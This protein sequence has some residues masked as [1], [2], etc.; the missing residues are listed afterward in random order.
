MVGHARTL[1]FQSRKSCYFKFIKCLIIYYFSVRMRVGCGC[2]LLDQVML[3][4]I[5]VKVDSGSPAHNL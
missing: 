2:Y 5:Q 3:S 1:S 4:Q